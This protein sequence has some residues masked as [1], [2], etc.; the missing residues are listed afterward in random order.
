MVVTQTFPW[1]ARNINA[2]TIRR[3]THVHPYKELDTSYLDLDLI[4]LDLILD[5]PGNP[6]P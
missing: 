6:K 1:R 5:K 3:K 4:N 2:F